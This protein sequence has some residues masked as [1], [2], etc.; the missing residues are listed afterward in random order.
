MSSA[1]TGVDGPVDAVEAGQH[2]LDL[3][4]EAK[5][6]RRVLRVIAVQGNTARC[7]VA[8]DSHPPTGPRPSPT[9]TRIAV[10]RMVGPPHR[11]R[12]ERVEGPAGG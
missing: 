8:S 3:E 9:L 10:H 2:W 5:G 12:F 11:R 6:R 4:E 1:S 7:R